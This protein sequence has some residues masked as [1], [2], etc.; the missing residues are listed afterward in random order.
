ATPPLVF[1]RATTAPRQWPANELGA[2]AK[3]WWFYT[4]DERSAWFHTA[5]VSCIAPGGASTFHTHMRD[6]EGPYETFY[7]V[8]EGRALIRSEYGDLD[9]RD[10]PGGVFVPADASHQMINNGHDFLW[11]L[12]LSS[13]GDSGLRLD[14]Y[15]MPSG[16]D[17]PGYKDEY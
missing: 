3:P 5:C 8:L 16:V 17:R 9:I 12:T 11:Y 7:L 10:N 15:S 2:T 6:F 13:R 1:H 4:V 14:T